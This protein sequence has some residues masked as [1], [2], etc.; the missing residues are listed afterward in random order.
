MQDYHRVT[1]HLIPE[2]LHEIVEIIT[3]AL[4][5]GICLFE[6]VFTKSYP[7]AKFALSASCDHAVESAHK[8]L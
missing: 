3:V 2:L 8:H 5:R 4:N 6:D 1:S 7:W